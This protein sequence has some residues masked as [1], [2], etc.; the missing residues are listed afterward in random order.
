MCLFIKGA[1]A[2]TKVT[3]NSLKIKIKLQKKEDD[4]VFKTESNK[5]KNI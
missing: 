4:D 3:I 1:V 2:P 5:Q